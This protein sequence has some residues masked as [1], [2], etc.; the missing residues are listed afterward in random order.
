MPVLAAVVAMETELVGAIP[1]GP[2]AE[3]DSNKQTNNGTIIVLHPE[4][5]RSK[6][7]DGTAPGTLDFFPIKPLAGGK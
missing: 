5:G 6:A 1:F 3:T 4:D 2:Q 7:E